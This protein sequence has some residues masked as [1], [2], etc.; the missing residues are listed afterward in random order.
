MAFLHRREDTVS[1]LLR[2]GKK[3]LTLVDAQQKAKT[4][5]QNAADG[6]QDPGDLRTSIMQ[7][8]A[9]DVEGQLFSKQEL[10]STLQ[11]QH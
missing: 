11:S 3:V 7:S 4:S 8:S 2:E 5:F 10:Y 6:K 9:M 1:E